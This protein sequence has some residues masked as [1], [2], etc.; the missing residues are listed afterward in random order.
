MTMPTDMKQLQESIDRLIESGTFSAKSA[1][2]IA[3]LR[4]DNE[5]LKGKLEMAES[6][7]AGLKADLDT[8]TREIARLEADLGKA[9]TM[10]T[11]LEAREKK[12][13]AVETAKSVAEARAAA[14]LEVCGLVFR[15][16]EF[17]RNMIGT[18]PHAGTA[19][20]N[21]YTNDTVAVSQTITETEA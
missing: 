20:P 1:E 14:Y 4:A 6:R 18:A 3:E 5:K 19:N 9:T 17:R 13:V 2:G 12:M 8:K 11:D 7:I 16:T 21:Q 10:R 15:N